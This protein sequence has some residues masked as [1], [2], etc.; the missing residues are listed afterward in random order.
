MQI[1]TTALF[2]RVGG[3]FRFTQR[4]RSTTIDLFT[5]PSVTVTYTSTTVIFVTTSTCTAT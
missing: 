4:I 2:N 5:F 1:S 3:D